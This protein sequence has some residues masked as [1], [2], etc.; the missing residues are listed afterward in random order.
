MR[1]TISEMRSIASPQFEGIAS[2]ICQQK[3]NGKLINSIIQSD[4][5]GIA[6]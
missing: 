1:D 6:M 2:I 3:T 5:H 4:D